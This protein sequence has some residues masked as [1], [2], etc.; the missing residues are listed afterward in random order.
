MGD[1]SEVSSSRKLGEK[2]PYHHEGKEATA[3]CEK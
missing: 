2:T 1:I 3:D